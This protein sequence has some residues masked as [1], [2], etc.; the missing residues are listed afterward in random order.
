MGYGLR[1]IYFLSHTGNFTQA[2]G[3]PTALDVNTRL[4]DVVVSSHTSVDIE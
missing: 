3:E 4:S 1:D 2:G